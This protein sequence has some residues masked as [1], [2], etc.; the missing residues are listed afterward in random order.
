MSKYT[1]GTYRSL[2][3]ST[4]AKR[5][6]EYLMRNA[7]EKEAKKHKRLVEEMSKRK[8]F[9]GYYTKEEATAR[10]ENAYYWIDLEGGYWLGRVQELRALCMVK[11][12]DVYVNVPAELAMYIA[13]DEDLQ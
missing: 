1:C 7:R 11:G 12:G 5:C 10:L 3:A 8:F 4:V 6:D 2:P 13:S 9:G